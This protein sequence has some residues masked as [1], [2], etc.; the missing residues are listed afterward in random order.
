MKS[1]ESDLESEGH[2]KSLC[3]KLNKLPSVQKGL[4]LILLIRIIWVTW[5]V[6]TQ[7]LVFLAY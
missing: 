5:T 2:Y 1:F 4:L 6:S 7:K 3:S